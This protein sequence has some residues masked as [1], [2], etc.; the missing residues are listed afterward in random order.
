MKKHSTPLTV[1]FNEVDSYHVAWHGH[2]VAWMEVGRNDLAG[3]FGLDAGQLSE[4]GYLGPV[5]A[6]ELKYLNPARFN[7]RITV[8]T[9]LRPSE[10]AVLIFDSEIIGPD[11]RTLAVGS[12]THAITDMHGVLQLRVPA[13]IAER[14]ARMTAWLG[15]P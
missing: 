4:A 1:R 12:T 9:G 6:L 10:S 8:C 5:V 15:S 13:S 2:Y 7:D 11:G 14:V 3:R